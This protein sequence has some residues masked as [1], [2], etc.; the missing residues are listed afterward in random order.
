MTGESAAIVVAG[1]GAWGTI[2]GG[3]LELRK[4]TNGQGPIAEKIAELKEDVA[5]VKAD[6]RDLK[7]DFREHIRRNEGDGR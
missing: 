4:R 6:V 1:I 5:G 3:L 7:A 2:I